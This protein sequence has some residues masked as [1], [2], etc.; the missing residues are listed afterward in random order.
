[1]GSNEKFRLI[2]EQIGM[3]VEVVSLRDKVYYKM[4]FR[5]INTNDFY[6]INN[7]L[8]D[9]NAQEAINKVYNIRTDINNSSGKIYYTYNI[10]ITETKSYVIIYLLEC[11]NKKLDLTF[12]SKLDRTTD[13]AK[14]V[15]IIKSIADTGTYKNQYFTGMYFKNDIIIDGISIDTYKAN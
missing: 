11:I 4:Y 8:Y 12:K 5:D 9:S 14:I 2:G 1:M 7:T 10:L 15:E 3:R 6:L 13:K